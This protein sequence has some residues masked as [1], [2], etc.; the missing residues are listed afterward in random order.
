MQ[1]PAE[2]RALAE[3]SDGARCIV[4]V[5]VYEGSSAV[6]FCEAL[7][8]QAELHLIDPF[9]DESGWA[10]REGARA[11]PIA[12]RLVTARRARRDGPEIHWHV[13]RSQDV[14][15]CWQGPPVDLLFVDGDHHPEAVREDWDVWHP[16]I[17][18]DGVV[19]FHDARL[20]FDDGI[21][22]PGPTSVVSDLFRGPAK[23]QDWRIFLEVDGLVAVKRVA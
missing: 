13:T 2:T 16:H 18:A 23:L 4:N 5:G 12:T 8:N 1:T 21:G 15:R 22:N 17:S 11:T 19:A 20:D 9:E 14:G 7:G 10:L 3:L 6:V